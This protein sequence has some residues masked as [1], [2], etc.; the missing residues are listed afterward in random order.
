MQSSTLQGINKR[1][2]LG[3]RGEVGR[4]GGGEML[5]VGIRLLFNQFP[6]LLLLQ[7][8]LLLPRPA[9]RGRADC[10]VIFVSLLRC[11]LSCS[12]QKLLF[13]FSRRPSKCGMSKEEEERKKIIIK[14]FI[15]HFNIFFQ[16]ILLYRLVVFIQGVCCTIQVNHY[17]LFSSPFPSPSLSSLRITPSFTL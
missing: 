5:R 3:G 14:Q 7:L 13:Y 8:V 12:L 10:E 4:W 9:S 15:N 11:V 6:F 16:Y 2:M 1:D 17:F